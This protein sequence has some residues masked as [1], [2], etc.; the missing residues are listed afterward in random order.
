MKVKNSRSD[1]FFFLDIRFGN[2]FV[3]IN[4]ALFVFA[5]QN[6]TGEALILLV[7]SNL[8]KQLVVFLIIYIV[9]MQ[10]VP[11]IKC[12]LVLRSNLAFILK[13]M[14]GVVSMTCN[15]STSRHQLG[16][17]Y[18]DATPLIPQFFID[19]SGIFKVS[20]FLNNWVILQ[21]DTSG[22]APSPRLVSQWL[23][24]RQTWQEFKHHSTKLYL[25]ARLRL[26]SSELLIRRS[27][28]GAAASSTHMYIF[29][30]YFNG[31][32]G[33]FFLFS[34]QMLSILAYMNV[35]AAWIG[36]V[37][38]RSLSF[39]ARSTR[40]KFGVDKFVRSCTGN[41]SYWTYWAWICVCRQWNSVRFWRNGS[42][43]LSSSDINVQHNLKT[44]NKSIKSR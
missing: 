1:V 9:F 6:M 15:I 5:G 4:N 11:R 42:V 14:Q 7:T 26:L 44:R 40:I 34:L 28:L 27:F 41:P 16:L 31:S 3:Y 24:K 17:R 18:L 35:P 20:I 25:L 22:I 29:G 23:L 21:L 10:S 32:G 36:S 19:L 38:Q 37:F 43:R 33:N 12:A 2:A 39:E 30:G 13:H 8:R